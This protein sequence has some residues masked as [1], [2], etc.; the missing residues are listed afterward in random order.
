MKNGSSWSA[1]VLIGSHTNSVAL[2]HMIFSNSDRLSCLTRDLR[3]GLNT[4]DCPMCSQTSTNDMRHQK[5]ETGCL[6]SISLCYDLTNKLFHICMGKLH[7]PLL[8]I[9]IC[10][11]ATFRFPRMYCSSI[12]SKPMKQGSSIR[13]RRSRLESSVI[14]GDLHP[15]SFP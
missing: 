14:Q 12:C 8:P 7:S 2:F 13:S 3:A 1:I 11:F 6:R 9:P 4:T 15:R 5:D 10:E